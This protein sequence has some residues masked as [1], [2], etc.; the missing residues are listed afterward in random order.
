MDLVMEVLNT[1][2]RAMGNATMTGNVADNPLANH[3]T[4]IMRFGNTSRISDE[5]WRGNPK[6]RAAQWEIVA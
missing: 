5:T 1:S 2:I 3:G 6:E 4:N